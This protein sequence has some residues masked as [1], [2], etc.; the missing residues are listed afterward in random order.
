RRSSG[1]CSGFIASPL[2]PWP[3]DRSQGAPPCLAAGPVLLYRPGGTVNGL[4]SAAARRPPRRFS[5]PEGRRSIARGASPWYTTAPPSG[6]QPRRGGSTGHVAGTAAPPGLNPF[7]QIPFQ[8]LAPLAIDCR[9]SG[10]EDTRGLTTA[11]QFSFRTASRSTSRQA[12]MSGAGFFALASYSM[13][14]QPAN[15]TS[16]RA[17]RTAATSSAP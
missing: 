16:R 5:A 12:R 14:S 1:I 10:A 13:L 7:L 3:S 8:G 9:P 11:C 6:F 17:R 4:E 15:F 2:G